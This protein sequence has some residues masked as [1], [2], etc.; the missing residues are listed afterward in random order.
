[1]LRGPLWGF[2]L[3]LLGPVFLFE[4]VASIT[5]PTRFRP[6]NLHLP[7]SA[8]FCTVHSVLEIQ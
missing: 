5:F 6:T 7:V 4:G 1:M 8:Y 3:C 2:S